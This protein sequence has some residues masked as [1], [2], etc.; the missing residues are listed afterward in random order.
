MS[1]L[2]PIAISSVIA[3][4]TGALAGWLCALHFGKGRKADGH[5]S[6]DLEDAEAQARELRASSNRTPEPQTE[7]QTEAELEAPSAPDAPKRPVTELGLSLYQAPDPI[8]V[9]R[10]W[11]RATRLRAKQGG[12]LAPSPIEAYLMRRLEEAG[13][14]E[15]SFSLP[16][17]RV[18]RPQ[19]NGMFYL[20]LSK[21]DPSYAD[22]LAMFGT[23]AALNAGVIAEELFAYNAPSSVE[24]VYAAFNTLLQRI[25]LQASNLIFPTP[26]GS[27]EWAGR[28]A[29][30]HA[31]ECLRLPYRLSTHF[32]M[33]LAEGEVGIEFE[34]T[35][36]SVFPQSTL[37]EGVGIV[38]TTAKMRARQRCDYTMR[39]AV[40]LA[41]CAFA[42]SSRVSRVWVAAIER[43][44]ASHACLLSTALTRDDMTE[45]TLDPS[46]DVMAILAQADTRLQMSGGALIP[47]QQA[48][49]LDDERFCP[50]RRYEPIGLSTRVLNQGEAKALG[51]ERVCGLEIDEGARRERM[52]E[53]IAKR[54]PQDGSCSCQEAVRAILEL[55]SLTE[56]PALQKLASQTAQ[57]L[58]DGSLEPD[59]LDIIEALCGCDGLEDA[60]SKAQELLSGGQAHQAEELMSRALEPI[61]AA[62]TYVDGPRDEWRAFSNYVDRVL[63]NL[64]LGREGITTHLVPSIYVE[65]LVMHSVTLLATNQGNRAL[66]LARRAAAICPMSAMVRLHLIQCL[67]ILGYDGESRQQ[68]V[69][70]LSQAHDPEG[71]GYGYYRMSMVLWQE[72]NVAASR[73]AFQR[74]LS[75]MPQD[76]ADLLRSLGSVMMGARFTEQKAFT[77]QEMQQVLTSA[78]VPFAPTEQVSEA[79]MGA[80]RAS[81][82][83]EIF[84]VARDFLRV[85]GSI[86]HSDVMFGVLR[87]LEDEP[88]R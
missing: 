43:T 17:L 88:D 68:L 14:A 47:C 63:Y 4:S 67:D 69:M 39:V 46:Q 10:E 85:L 42:A 16:G 54:I 3:F 18:V 59:P 31:I 51:T 60:L 53:E 26:S 23:E 76:A 62:N 40:L 15:D 5:N 58:V 86:S 41:C 6:P 71:L 9:L 11:A 77:L 24:D 8:A 82:D 49:S 73:A 74:A 65:A 30:S 28:L 37:V 7:Q 20:R 52:A 29:L 33:N 50:R 64:V 21:K 80:A 75:F 36:S 13:I 83:A 1:L 72:G 32:R 12:P 38:P 19:T 87:S 2:V 55:S 27:G 35:P 70:L 22:T 44:P 45:L 48:F 34:T 66:A 57:R 56:D 61:D 79:F 81:L 78:G 84:P 25:T